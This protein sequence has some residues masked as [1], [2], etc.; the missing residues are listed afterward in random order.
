MNG[1]AEGAGEF[2]VADAKLLPTF[3]NTKSTSKSVKVTDLTKLKE[4]ETIDMMQMASV[5]GASFE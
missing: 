1:K 5:V 4:S 2:I 3:K